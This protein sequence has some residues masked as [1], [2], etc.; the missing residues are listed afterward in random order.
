MELSFIKNKWYF[1]KIGS[2]RVYFI[3]CNISLCISSS[4]FELKGIPHLSHMYEGSDDI[5]SMITT[6]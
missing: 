2:Y 6:N 5:A 1:A 3:E 4:P